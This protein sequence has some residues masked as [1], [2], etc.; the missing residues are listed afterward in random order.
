M[1]ST[2]VQYTSV[3]Q[4]SDDSLGDEPKL[5]PRRRGWETIVVAVTAVLATATTIGFLS[6]SQTA[7]AELSCPQPFLRREWRALS[8]AEQSE[9]LRAVQCL[10]DLPSGLGLGG[11]R[12]DDFPWL[13]F[14]V[15]QYG[16][17]EHCS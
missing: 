1:S 5:P 12:S 11:K 9:Y 10:H 6:V 15:G 17:F 2:G 14:N 4:E 8:T 13:H 7:T 3:S 16:K